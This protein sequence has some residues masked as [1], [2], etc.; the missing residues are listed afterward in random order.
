MYVVNL[1]LSNPGKLDDYGS[2]SYCFESKFKAG[3]NAENDSQCSGSLLDD[4]F[5]RL[6]VVSQGAGDRVNGRLA[7]VG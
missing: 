3:C 1:G 5:H 7:D 6:V 2:V 4:I